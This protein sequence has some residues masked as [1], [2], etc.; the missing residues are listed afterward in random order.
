MAYQERTHVKRLTQYFFK[1]L[2]IV[3]PLALTLFVLYTLFVRIDSLLGMERTGLGLLVV[4]AATTA[5]GFFASHFVTRHLFVLVDRLFARLPLVKML[6]GAI[7]DLVGAF[8][9][10]R[11]SFD[12]P[13]LVEIVPGSEARVIGFLTRDE[14]DQFGLRD[15]V[16]VYLPQS[17]NFAGNL[18]VVPRERVT[19]LAGDSA[20]T[21]AFVVSGGVST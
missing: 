11:R 6:Y 16:A 20:R 10:D 2:L 9:G 19:R 4:V 12:K 17:Y 14:L 3:V 8:V 15:H 5:I 21:M 18:L 13:V 7:R 1:G